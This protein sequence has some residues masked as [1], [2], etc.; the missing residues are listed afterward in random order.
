MREGIIGAAVGVMA[1]VGLA[2][3][4][5]YPQT[6]QIPV[7]FFDYHSDGS[8]PDFNPGT[9]PGGSRGQNLPF[10][11]L[12]A[13]TLDADG[14]PVRGDSMLFSY[15]VN[16]WFRPWPQ[17]N[18]GQGS[19]FM[20]PTYGVGGNPAGYGR[21]MTQNVVFD[22][23]TSYKNIVIQDSLTFTY[24]LAAGVGQ[25]QFSVNPNFFPLDNQGFG[26][27]AATKDWNYYVY[28]TGAVENG[29]QN[30]IGPA[31][32]PNNA[33]AQD[34]P[35][36]PHNYSFAMHLNRKFIVRL[37]LTFSF[38]GDDDL[39]VFINGKLVLDMGGM[40]NNMT[41]GFALD[42]ML[43]QLGLV[44]GQ[45]ATIDIFYCE[46]QATGSNITITT[47][48][49]NTPY[50]NMTVVPNH[51]TI[52]AGDSIHMAGQVIDEFGS[53]RSDL[54]LLIAWRVE[55]SLTHSSTGF[56]DYLRTKLPQTDSSNEFYAVDAY[57]WYDIIAT[58]A[59]VQE[60]GGTI[61]D[62]IHVF[63]KPG[64]ANHLVIEGYPYS[65]TS[66]YALISPNADKPL[67]SVTFSGTML[68]DSVDAILRDSFGNFVGFA[69]PV[70]WSSAPLNIVS[71][72]TVN[73]PLGEGQITKIATK[74]TFTT[75]TASQTG[76]T[77]GSVQVLISS[78]TYSKI[79][80]VSNKV[81]VADIGSLAM[82]TDQ[83]T[84]LW[85]KALR[86]DGSN[87]W[88]TVQV[89]WGSSAYLKYTIP[90]PYGFSWTVEPDTAAAGKIFISMGT[91]R[92]TINATFSVG[93]PATM[94]LYP[95]AGPPN[96]TGNAAYGPSANVVAGQAFPLYSKIF[97]NNNEWLSAYEG[98]GAS[99]FAWTLTD[100]QN[101]PTTAGTLTSNGSIASF[102]GTVAGK[103]VKVTATFTGGISKSI[104][105]TIGPATASQ[106]VIEPDATGQTAYPNTPHRAGTVTIGG[107]STNISVYAVLRDPYGNFV[108]FSDPT[109]WT[110]RTPATVGDS[111]GNA[112]LGEGVCTRVAASG[113]AYVVAQD[114]GNPALHDSVLVVLSS[115]SYT[116]LRIVVR[117]SAALYNHNLVMSI[118]QDTILKVQGLRSD[119]TGWD[120]V[121]ATWAAIGNLQTLTGAPGASASWHVYPSDTGT[122]WIKVTMGSAIPDSVQVTFLHGAPH[123]IVLYPLVGPPGP[124]NAPYF[125]P[126]Y[127]IA[128]T[129]GVGVPVVA[130]V[131]DKAGIW[132]SSYE[133]GTSPVTWSVYEFTGNKLP[134]TGSV[135]PTN[136]DATA[137]TPT[138][139]YNSVY[140][141]ATYSDGSVVARDSIQLHILPGLPTQLVIEAVWDSSQSLNADRRLG[142]FTM[143][144]TVLKDSVFAVLRDADS[145]FVGRA[146]AATWTSRNTGVVTAA[147]ASVPMGEGEI[148]RQTPNSSNTWVAVTQGALKDSV[149]VNLDA[150]G[151]SQIQ[152]VVRGSVNIDT[153]QM[154]TDQDTTLM[155]RGLRDDGSGIWDDLRV[156]WGSSG[157][158]FDKPAP[159]ADT[160]SWSLS[161][162]S[163]GSGKIF[164][165]WTNGIVQ[166]T[167]TIVAIFSYGNPAVMALYPAAGQPNTTTNV[168]YPPTDTV[169]AGVP[170]PIVAKLFTQSNDWLSGY[171]R[172]D[173]PFTWTTDPPG[174]ATLLPSSGFQTSF[175]G[176]K[177]Y[178]TVT[179]TATYTDA[180]ITLSKSIKITITP[181]PAAFL[182]IEPD[183]T[184]KTAYP[185]AAHRAG[186]VAILG[187]DTSLA[188][189][190]VLRDQ[191]GNFVG[192]S[193]PTAWLSRDTTQAAVTNGDPTKGTGIL[194]R[195]TNLGQ[196]WVIAHDGKTPAFTDSVLVVLSNVSYTALRIVVRDSTK[197]SS[198]TMAIE[199]DTVLQVQGLRSDNTGWDYVPAAWSMSAG[200]TTVLAPP[201]ASNNWNVSPTN[202]GSGVIRVSLGSAKP[203]SVLVQFTAGAA[204]SIVLY[205]A[206]GDPAKQQPYPGVNQAIIDSAGEA[207]PVFAKVFD[208]AGNWLSSYESPSAPITWSIVEQ[209]GNTDVP[210]GSFTPATGS[211]TVYTPTRANNTVLLTA[212]F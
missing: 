77:S 103:T 140:V 146:T 40:H 80:I 47:N 210:T 167:D 8:C 182:V 82:R 207:L 120:S 175:T 124:G 116:V 45:P 61:S 173:A 100:A 66:P 203:D 158:S 7:T 19:D 133:T 87:I 24:D 159:A 181:G 31:G 96:G 202:T 34:R 174:A 194:L 37:G 99:G 151:Y 121:P 14:L 149:Q 148:T 141:I 191:F 154:R 208:K 98:A 193:N 3:A 43:N 157:L 48:L 161:P 44:L 23:D 101:N 41:G 6:M 70:T 150:V 12:V 199:Q 57:H 109:T 67:G 9:D 204:R 60:L 132:L 107:G 83:D 94:A 58:V 68:Y 186:Q 54:S 2:N 128:D 79:I 206:A 56:R 184:G 115:I 190:A 162:A 92:D 198:L 90:P 180:N 21:V 13:N 122:G 10:L 130:K 160:S 29:G 73:A 195:R 65:L 62:T 187:T 15:Y 95:N 108:S 201:G 138:R 33:F 205:P 129:A 177:A 27:D 139:A 18:Y 147:Y 78:V 104:M 169:V 164:I 26:A 144:S 35:P 59:N 196:A 114:V 5:T 152:I 137:F 166:R 112:A 20:R 131:F 32:F 211:S 176:V 136:G 192:F 55:N 183:T 171:E 16:K 156:T 89:Q 200:L 42:G 117:D 38:R 84:L 165:L 106:L 113:Q 25:Y 209:Q 155:A 127:P 119:G 22:K 178:Q 51:D 30:Y 85:A 71:V 50:I 142:S 134:P 64:A 28:G 185:N 72:A 49:L 97:S 75:V 145:N 170:F 197:I 110:A 36:N 86:A 53:V 135:I 76:I 17:S 4:Q 153:L 189:Y 168:A 143:G 105:I 163:P 212:E 1:L 111:V 69:N 118:D 188:V 88:D 63:I 179:V 81:A 126:V 91:L 39:W 172:S 52:S 46:R 123:S 74:D 125:D 93:L 11:G 102:M